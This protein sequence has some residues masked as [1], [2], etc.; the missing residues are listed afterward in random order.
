MR[1]SR[2]PSQTIK[3]IPAHDTSALDRGRVTKAQNGPIAILGTGMAGLGAAHRLSLEGVPSTLYDANKYPGGHTA[4]HAAGEGFVFDDGPHVSF[5]KDSRVRKLLAANVNGEFEE[6]A[7]R[8]NNYWRGHWIP[9]PVQ[10]HL[11]G[12]PTELIIKVIAD[13]VRASESE[14]ADVVTYEDWLRAAYGDAFAETFPIVYGRKYHTTTMDRLTTE[15][16]GPRMYRPTLEELLRGALAPT[17][18]PVHYVTSFRYPTRGGFQAYLRAFIERFD[19]RLGYAVSAIDARER[20]IRFANGSSA[21]YQRLI[22][23][24]PLPDLV[25]LIDSAPAR[26]IAAARDLAFTSAVMVNLGVAR[27][28]LSTAHISYV[29]D[30]DLIFPRLNFPHLLSPSNVPPGAGSVQVEL[31]F[32]DKYRPLETG[33]DALI[34][35]VIKDLQKCGVLREDDR[36]LVREARFVRYANVIYDHERAAALDVV[37]AFLEEIGIHYCGRYGC[38]DHTWTDEAFLSGERAAEAALTGPPPDR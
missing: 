1:S 17:S 38:W 37:H 11:H 9:H 35:P 13:F 25:P 34:E 10:M 2:R 20:S 26:V 33:P 22:S 28:D 32:S 24:I 7:A 14:R 30:E 23:S 21:T 19:I 15:W 18:A 27:E 16:L 3:T 12:L 36:L 8:I 5:T 31:Y 6:I 29:Y 4:T